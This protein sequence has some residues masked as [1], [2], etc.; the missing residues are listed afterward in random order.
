MLIL[1]STNQQLPLVCSRT[2]MLL[3]DS[4]CESTVS[5]VLVFWFM[6]RSCR[7]SQQC[8]L[9]QVV[10]RLLLIHLVLWADHR[11]DPCTSCHICACLQALRLQKPQFWQAACQSTIRSSLP[12]NGRTKHSRRSLHSDAI[13]FFT[14]LGHGSALQTLVSTSVFEN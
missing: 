12:C 5:S 3:A 2:C 9:Q 4:P 10:S 6:T 1:S 13:V 14:F 7:L 11:T 8:T